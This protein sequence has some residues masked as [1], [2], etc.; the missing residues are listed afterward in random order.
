[1]TLS[2][3]TSPP[4]FS[5]PELLDSPPSIIP[6]LSLSEDDH[7]HVG[8]LQNLNLQPNPTQMLNPVQRKSTMVTN[9]LVM[10]LASEL[11]SFDVLE[12]KHFKKF[13]GSLSPGYML[14][15]QRV[16]ADKLLEEKYLESKINVMHMLKCVS[17]LN[18]LLDVWNSGG[19]TY[20]GI[21][22][23]YLK[24]CKM[25]QMVLCCKMIE[26]DDPAEEAAHYFE[27]TLQ[28]FGLSSKII[29]VITDNI[30]NA[31]NRFALQGFGEDACN[32]DQLGESYSR[33][34]FA[35]DTF[36][37][38]P[39]AYFPCFEYSL[40]EVITAGFESDNDLKAILHKVAQCISYSSHSM[41]DEDEDIYGWNTHIKLIR[42]FLNS[43]Q[44]TPNESCSDFVLNSTERDVLKDM[45]DI[46][47]PFEEAFA[48]CKQGSL[49][50]TGYIVPCIRGLRHYLEK[51]KP[52][53]NKKL[54]SI[55][56]SRLDL[57][58]LTHE[59]CGQFKLAAVLDPRFKLNWCQDEDERLAV[60]SQLLREASSANRLILT[61]KEEHLHNASQTSSSVMTPKEDNGPPLSKKSKLFS[62]MY[63]STEQ[64]TSSENLRLENEIQN[65][66]EQPRISEDCNILEF[67]KSKQQIY[68]TL[69]KLAEKY[70]IV[71]ITSNSILSAY[72]LQRDGFQLNR[73]QL[74]GKDFE[75]AMFIRCNDVAY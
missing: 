8:F 17:S 60:R 74:T 70:L 12:N 66:L 64:K 3:V 16:F 54:L 56:K 62:F 36:A 75:A 19:R 4:G 1:M 13:V 20:L 69:A 33:P 7:N 23:Q 43:V 2:D 26:S 11:I 58:L 48:Y 49:L 15:S 9:E 6:A 35:Q 46:V 40:R 59:A 68:P 27:E 30:V 5:P 28:W 65:Y 34:P 31:A 41:L 52:K 39:I 24:D 45:L 25:Q 42:L 18:V 32:D 38:L 14:P 21:A 22:G 10:F 47:E 44:Q 51:L 57:W 37:F 73:C 53:Y 67:W 71:P 61:V 29:C 50:P 72:K 63:K 55:L